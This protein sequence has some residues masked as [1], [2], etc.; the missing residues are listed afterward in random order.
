MRCRKNKYLKELSEEF[1][2]LTK[3]ENDG[4]ELNI[5]KINF[6]NLLTETVLE[7]H[8]WIA[9]RNITTNFETADCIVIQTDL[10]CLTRI[11]NNLMSN[12]QKYTADSFGVTLK[13]EENRVILE[14]LDPEFRSVENDT[15]KIGDGVKINER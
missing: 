1:F 4:K 12:V 5:G 6:I 3:I 11:L 8:S 15:D 10:H 7:Q 14:K 13:Q 2:E 9:Q